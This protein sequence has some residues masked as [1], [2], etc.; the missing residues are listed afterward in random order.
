MKWFKHDT[1]ARNDT[2][3]KLLKR[4]F[5]TEG[6][7]VYFQL[8]EIVGENIKEDNQDDWAY[9]EEIHTIETL[10]AEI[11]VTPDKLR[12]ILGY[13][14]D[15]GLL[16]KLNGKLCIPKI[17]SRLDEY[18]RKRKGDFDVV[19]REK[20]LI[21]QCRDKV[22]TV[23]GQSPGLEQNRLEQ[24]RTDKK[25]ERV[26]YDTLTTLTEKEFQLIATD[27]QIPIAFVR[28]VYDDLVN[29]CHSKGKTYKDYLAALRNW[30]KKDAIK[31]KEKGAPHGRRIAVI[32]IPE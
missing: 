29:Y 13:C 23:S 6:Y 5:K 4:K 8:L 15:I 26:E 2:R 30:T 14:N 10:A 1:G 7:A 18:A 16:Y 17:L 3:I 32:P 19:Q 20:E 27:Y 9:V 24:N 31:L 12:T 21:G 22:R 25:R 11:G 28:N